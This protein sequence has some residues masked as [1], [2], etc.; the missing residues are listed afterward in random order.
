MDE[1]FADKFVAMN[2]Y[3]VEFA[4]GMKVFEAEAHSFGIRGTVDKIPVVGQIFALE[5]IMNATFNTIMTGEPHPALASR[6]NTQISILEEELKRPG[7]SNRTKELIR[8]D[9]KDIK[10][11]TAALDK[12]M[13]KDINFKSSH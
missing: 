11:Q 7:I 6:L 12:L 8:K 3:G 4:T 13:K 10:D 1:S 2:G 5:Y 9:I